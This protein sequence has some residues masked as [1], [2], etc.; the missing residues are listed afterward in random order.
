M[1]TP[2]PPMN[3]QVAHVRR[4]AANRRY[5]QRL[6]MVRLRWAV[7]GL[8]VVVLLVEVL[9]ATCFSPRF[10]VHSINVRGAQILTD[11]DVIRLMGLPARSNFF[12]APLG[13][14]AKKIAADPRVESATVTRG[15]VGVLQVDVRERAALC[16]LDGVRPAVYMDGHGVLFY[17]RS[18]PETPVP[19]VDG[20]PV[21][22]GEM[23]L[24]AP[25]TQETALQVRE[26]LTALHDESLGK[27]RLPVSR[28]RIDAKAGTFTLILRSGT[29][30][31]LGPP[32][33]FRVK[34]WFLHTFIVQASRDGLALDQID[35]FD[36]SSVTDYNSKAARMKPK[37]AS[38]V[39]VNVN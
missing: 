14:L 21:K 17:R 30:V 33:Q 25:L 24:G 29:K 6:R 12:R 23:R 18:A 37:H 5:R 7:S 28:V 15:E 39:P 2:L 1:E 38:A 13:A 16:R 26:C 34:T 35:Y 36:L 19:V 4:K 9:L 10:W 3:P 22:I 27:A 11:I 31:F 32:R 8:L 20:L